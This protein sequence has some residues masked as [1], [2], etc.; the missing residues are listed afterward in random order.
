MALVSL[1]K[2]I[3]LFSS[4]NREDIEIIAALLRR[5]SI[6]KGDIIFQKGD[7]GTALYAILSGRIKIIV[8][9]PVGDKITVAILNDGD[10]F[11]EM[12]LLDGMPRSA[13]AVALEETQ[14]AVLDRNDF[15]AFLVQHEH[16]VLAILRT[17]SLR[18][19]KTD[20]LLSEICFLSLSARLAKRLLELARG[21]SEGGHNISSLAM[22]MTQKELSNLLGVS[23]ESVNKELKTLRDKGIVSTERS[24]IVILDQERL[25][26]RAK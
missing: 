14:L 10:F 11:G 22:R 20:D 15:L 16:A 3:P 26:K 8:T 13:D 12:A 23:R 6:K 4:L 19:R 2:Q 5:R 18:L 1:I 24:K 9:R 21:E 25:K 17:L 7:E